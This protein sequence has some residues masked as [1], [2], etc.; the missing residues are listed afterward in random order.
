MLSNHQC[1]ALSTSVN[2]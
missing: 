1:A 2:T